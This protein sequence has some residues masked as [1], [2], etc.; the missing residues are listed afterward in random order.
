M[1]HIKFKFYY[2]TG[3]Q[4]LI[5]AIVFGISSLDSRINIS[6][7]IVIFSILIGIHGTVQPFVKKYKNNYYQELVYHSLGL[8][9]ISLY[10]QGASNTIAVNIMV[11]LAAI[12]I[13]TYLS[14]L[15]LCNAM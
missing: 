4:L 3:L 10:S 13:I 1:D 2:W 15:H 11:V 6:I 14:H 8:Y 9:V 7:S 12:L 5:Q